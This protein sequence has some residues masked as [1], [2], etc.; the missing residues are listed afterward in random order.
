ERRAR[1]E[2]ERGTGLTKP[3]MTIQEG[4]LFA[5]LK[6]LSN[7]ERTAWLTNIND[8]AMLLNPHQWLKLGSLFNVN[9]KV[10]RQT[11]VLPRLDILPEVLEDRK[12]EVQDIKPL[13]NYLELR[14]VQNRNYARDSVAEGIKLIKVNKVKEAMEH[15]KRA[16]DMDPKYADGWFHVAEAFVQQ[17]KLKEAG[18]QL[19]KALKIEADHEGAKA[20]LA[21]KKN[22]MVHLP[23]KEEAHLHKDEKEARD[24]P[25]TDTEET[26]DH[27]R[28]ERE[29]MIL[30]GHPRVERGGVILHGHPRVEKEEKARRED[31][32]QKKVVEIV[33]EKVEE[34]APK[35]VE[36]IAPK[37]VEEIAQE[38]VE[39]IAQEKDEE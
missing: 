7:V 16:L 29:E 27:P 38:K 35:K 12:I 26:H 2:K 18:E 9:S 19:E 37:K 1:K 15:Y 10:A 11:S 21:S 14:D 22:E 30:P 4:P 34:I 3:E 39:E 36:E 5:S 24:H 32:V 13:E 17:K 28:V 33:Q 8:E 23:K 25:L 31:I 6:D 20:L